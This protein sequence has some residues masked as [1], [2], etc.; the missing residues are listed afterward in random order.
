MRYFL[1]SSLFFLT[2]LFLD[3]WATAVGT[4]YFFAAEKEGNPVAVLAW[5]LLGE[6][7]WMASFLYALTILGAGL[8]FGKIKTFLGIWWFSS[9]GTGHIIG[10]LSWQGIYILPFVNSNSFSLALLIFISAAAGFFLALLLKNIP[11]HFYL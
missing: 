1:F 11:P 2:A 3:N 4:N 6:W 7:R 9:F 5:E 10:F 8:F